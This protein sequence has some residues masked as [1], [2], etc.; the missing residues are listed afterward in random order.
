MAEARQLDG[1]LL[2]R[3]GDRLRARVGANS[4]VQRFIPA[5]MAALLNFSD[6]EAAVQAALDAFQHDQLPAPHEVI[7]IALN[8][9]SM[10]L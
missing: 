1:A 3:V 5:A 9:G 7:N 4:D 2:R 10:V 6:E 8:C